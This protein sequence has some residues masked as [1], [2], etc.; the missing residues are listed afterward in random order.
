[1]SYRVE[2]LANTDSSSELTNRLYK[3]DGVFDSGERLG[4]SGKLGVH[5]P[6]QDRKLWRY[7][8]L[9]Q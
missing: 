3:S 6:Q 7:L 9:N 8:P 2:T 5:Y 4:L 1:M